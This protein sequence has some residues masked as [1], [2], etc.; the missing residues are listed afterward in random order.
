MSIVLKFIE[1]SNIGIY[2][3]ILSLRFPKKTVRI[4][5]AIIIISRSEN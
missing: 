1:N 3:F 2:D 5:E 4:D